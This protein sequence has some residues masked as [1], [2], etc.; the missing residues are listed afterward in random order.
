MAGFIIGIVVGAFF[1]I[2]CM[3]LV[4]AASNADDAAGLN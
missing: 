4:S 3:A 2:I 1:G